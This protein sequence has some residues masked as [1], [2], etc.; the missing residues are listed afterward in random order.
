[1]KKKQIQNQSVSPEEFEAIIQRGLELIKDNKSPSKSYIKKLLQHVKSSKSNII[2]KLEDQSNIIDSNVR[3]EELLLIL[4]AKIEENQVLTKKIR[5]LT[6]T[7]DDVVGLITHEFKNI[8][9][10]VH[11]YNML[12]EREI[13]KRQ[14]SEL[15][16]NLQASDRL[17][18]QLSDM[19]DSLL[20][21]SLGEKGLLDPE[22]KLVDLMDDVLLPVEKDLASALDKN[23]MSLVIEGPN[24]GIILEADDNLV[25]IVIRNL[26]INAIKYGKKKTAIRIK[27][28][29]K[30]SDVQVSV[31]NICDAVPDDFCKGI[32]EKFHKKKIGN[33]K[34]GTGLG[35][36]N[37]KNII[38]LHKGQIK[39]SFSGGKWIEFKFTLP[40]Y[41]S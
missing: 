28:S 16:Q 29:I 33:R 32:F 2:N 3:V 21:M 9:T 19:S 24:E 1:M 25:D 22:Y 14:N 20:K 27:V 39:C 34:G 7:Y 5:E 40:Q 37:V 18:R 12:L 36:Y 30:G 41:Q 31:K 10:S 4:L 6:D 11:G 26:L 23:L 13:S 8:L 17:T 35:L 15:I 38:S